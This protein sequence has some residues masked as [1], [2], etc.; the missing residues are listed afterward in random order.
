MMDTIL[1]HLPQLLLAWSIQIVAVTS[2]GPAVA[3]IL[4]VAL[5]RGR[6]PALDTVTGI[7]CGATLAATATMLGMAAVLTQFAELMTVIRWLGAGYLAYLAYRAFRTAVL[8]PPVGIGTDATSGRRHFLRGFILQLSNPK[9]LFFWLAIAAAAGMGTVPLPVLAAFLSGAFCISFA[10]HALWALAL[11]SSPVR[12]G[13]LAARRR[14]EGA[15]G[16]FFAYFALRLA[17][18]RS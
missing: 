6:K 4:G 1:S 13:Y 7:A 15:L 10:G 18:E 11:S 8:L 5:A 3:L 12:R 17:T 2:P 16:L 14:V 9:A